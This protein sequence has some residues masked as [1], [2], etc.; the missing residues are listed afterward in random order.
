MEHK[1]Y[2]ATN[3]HSKSIGVHFN[4]NGHT[5]SDMEITTIAK[6]FSQDPRFRDKERNFTY[7]NSTLDTKGWIESM[8]V[9]DCQLQPVYKKTI[10]KGR[11]QKKKKN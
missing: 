4:L 3:N 9:E 2:V 8:G 6:I 5:V 7:K 1:N 11:V 10:V